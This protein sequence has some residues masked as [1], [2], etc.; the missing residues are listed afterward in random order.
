M[1]C[2]NCGSKLPDGAKFCSFCGA[3]QESAVPVTDGPVPEEL[4]E[5]TLSIFGSE[6]VKEPAEEKTAEI[7]EEP[8]NEAPIIYRPDPVPFTE[9]VPPVDKKPKK[10]KKALIAAILVVLLAVGGYF[11][12]PVAKQY[13]DYNKA[14]KAYESGDTATAM[15][16]F[17]ELSKDEFKDSKWYVF[18]IIYEDAEALYKSGDYAGAVEKFSSLESIGFR[19]TKK[20]LDTIFEEMIRMADEHRYSDARKIAQ[21]FQ[22][23]GTRDG[24]G[25]ESYISGLEAYSLDQFYNAYVLFQEAGNIGDAAAMAEKCILPAPSTG[26]ILEGDAYSSG[27]VDLKIIAPAGEDCYVKVYKDGVLSY[28]AYI[29]GGEDYTKS[30]SSGTYSINVGYGQGRWFGPDD[31]FGDEGNY[32]KLLLGEDSYESYMESNMI[33]TLTLKVGTE[34]NVGNTNTDREGM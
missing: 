19:D 1:F 17:Q 3:S 5:E 9:P 7:P 33:Y 2:M 26:T 10:K 13:I 6:V 15:P 28:T 31:M 24:V 21:A 20:Y 29:R 22:K 34:G 18:T 11:G 14:V 23:A 8:Q 4:N 12:Y 16:I 27:S 32:E 25:A 30:L